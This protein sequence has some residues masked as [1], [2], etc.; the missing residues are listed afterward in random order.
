[1]S[2]SAIP[3]QTGEPTNPPWSCDA[4]RIL[5]DGDNGA[6]V[7]LK[8]GEMLEIDL[9]SNPSTGYQWLMDT[10]DPAVLE[11]T[12]G[13]YTSSGTALGSG[14]M[15]KLCF[16]ARKA[17]QVNLKLGYRR[18]WEKNIEPVKVFAAAVQVKD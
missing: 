7:E 9:A 13:D 11:Q 18:V 3:G 17:G 1:M 14:G 10:G 12:A 4:V 5:G 15:Q 2:P 16:T 6:L 8:P